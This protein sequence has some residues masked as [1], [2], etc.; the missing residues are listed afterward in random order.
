MYLEGIDGLFT[1]KKKK[2]AR[3]AAAAA[4]A[5]VEASR[6]A[7]ENA[8]IAALDKK[9]QDEYDASIRQQATLTTAIA[10][11]IAQQNDAIAQQNEAI[12]TRQAIQSIRQAIQSSGVAQTAQ[13]NEAIKPQQA[14]Q[15]SG[16]DTS[17]G[18]FPLSILAS[19]SELLYTPNNEEFGNIEKVKNMRMNNRGLSG[20]GATPGIM[21]TMTN[22]ADSATRSLEK[23]LPLYMQMKMYNTQLKLAKAQ[24]LRQ[25]G[26]IDPTLFQQ[27]NIRLPV[28]VGI[29][30]DTQNMLMIGG[31]LLL[32]VLLMKG[33]G[34]K[35]QNG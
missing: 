31:G 5:A 6:E 7:A 9:A 16:L 25:G 27:S 24:A 15:S 2:R 20:L 8:R 28:S 22:A 4:A 33:Q 35:K 32:L 13:Q 30:P 3:A 23:L 21:D 10:A 26:L 14:I 18:M 17:G 11:Q 12:K 29:N 34:G 19:Q 1:S